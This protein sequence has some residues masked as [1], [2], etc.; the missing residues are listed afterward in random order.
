MRTVLITAA[1]S[2]I[3]QALATSKSVKGIF[4]PLSLLLILIGFGFSPAFGEGLTFTEVSKQAGFDYE[5]GYIPGEKLGAKVMSGGVAAG[6]YDGDGWVDLYIVRGDIGPNLLFRNLGNGTFE[7][8]GEKAGVALTRKA[9]SGP[10][11]ADY[12]GDGYLDLFLGGL[13]GTRPSL[14]R[15]RGDGSFENLTDESGIEIDHPTFSAAFGDYDRDGDLDLFLT[16]WG[17]RKKGS[18]HH[19]WRNN[20]DGSF[21]DVSVE[22]GISQ[23]FQGRIDRTFTPNFADI[24]SDGWPDLLIASD[25]G[26]SQVFINNRDGTFTNSTTPAISDENGMGAAVGDYDNDGDLDWFVSSVFDPVGKIEGTWG[27]SGNRLYRN[28]GDG[29]FEDATDE[30]GVR[31]GLW[32]WGSCF[33]DFNNDGFLDIFHVN[34]FIYSPVQEVG[35]S[36]E[37]P[38]IYL[39]TEGINSLSKRLIPQFLNDPSRLFISSGDG[40]FVERAQELGI[41]DTGQ[42]RGVVCFDYDR[43]GDLDIFVA[44]FG[45]SPRLYRNDGGNELNFLNIKL[46]GPPPNTEAVGARIFLSAGGKT[47]MREF[48]SGSNFVSQDPVE[49]HFGLGGSEVVERI[50]ITWPD[51]KRKTLRNVAANQF[52]VIEYP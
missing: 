52:L 24:D 37:V 1:S 8:V 3:R 9:G 10:T 22:A 32:G 7:E 6:D 41:D 47:Q 16:H 21:N 38:K 15:N 28:R 44:N 4:Y 2:F 5:H 48:R 34:G 50:R 17:S 27:F 13:E 20:G 18:T 26:T 42:G 36:E 46:K 19:L 11:F 31:D 45:E 30:A 39:P 25:Y 29:T 33:A 51:G 14:F 43:D 49:A 35:D 12:D 23:S 40:G